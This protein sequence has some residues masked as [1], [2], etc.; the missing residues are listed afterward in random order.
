M[1]RARDH[2]RVSAGADYPTASSSMTSSQPP[3]T[4]EVFDRY[5]ALAIVVGV[6][7]RMAPPA[8]RRAQVAAAPHRVREA[9]DSEAATQMVALRE[10]LAASGALAHLT[11]REQTFLLTPP[12][13]LPDA[14]WMLATARLEA[15][16]AL[17]WALD[18]LPE[19]PPCDAEP[20][21]EIL[22]ALENAG[23]VTL[24][25]RDHIE[26]MR[27]I[28]G[29]WYWRSQTRAIR[30]GLWSPPEGVTMKQLDDAVLEATAGALADGLISTTIDGDVAARGKAFRALTGTEWRQ[31]NTT[32]TQRLH[33][34]NWLCGYAPGNEWDATPLTI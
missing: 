23:T 2:G 14:E 32:T 17:G 22:T 33:A 11:V 9:V 4:A 13:Q 3:S 18:L 24:R 10:Q 8:Q 1:R 16:A 26:R 5:W 21:P 20:S 31:V 15:L 30:D 27:D 7:V 6:A 29:F 25:A 28:A 19:L 12:H 34:L